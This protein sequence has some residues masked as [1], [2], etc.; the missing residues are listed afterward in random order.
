M[1]SRGGDSQSGCLP[2]RISINV[3]SFVSSSI[4]VERDRLGCHETTN[5]SRPEIRSL[6]ASRPPLVTLLV[7]ENRLEHTRSRLTKQSTDE[8]GLHD[9]FPRNDLTFE[10]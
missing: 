3:S 8:L 7:S 6:F 10:L 5:Q 1:G 2:G 9:S 4:R